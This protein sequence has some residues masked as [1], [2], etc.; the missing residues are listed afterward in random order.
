MFTGV[1]FSELTKLPP[2]LTTNWMENRSKDRLTQFGQLQ[3]CKGRE[4]ESTIN[5]GKFQVFS[6][7][8][9]AEIIG[10]KEMLHNKLTTLPFMD[11]HDILF[12]LR[13]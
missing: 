7:K 8:I 9:W 13:E 12:H 2:T 6:T 4:K 11:Q 5:E 3:I 1:F 10:G